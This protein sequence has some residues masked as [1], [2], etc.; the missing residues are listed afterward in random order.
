M[1]TKLFDFINSMD[2]YEEDQV[3]EYF[4]DTNLAKNLKVYKVQ[5]FDLLMKSLTSYHSKRNINSR[6]RIGLEEIEILI[7]KQLYNSALVRLK[8]IKELCLQ[9]EA[10]SKLFQILEF[11]NQFKVHY[12]INPLPPNDQLFAEL[13]DAVTRTETA[14]R[15]QKILIELNSRK[16]AKGHRLLDEQE[17]QQYQRQLQEL[18]DNYQLESMSLKEKSFWY[19]S[20]SCIYDLIDEE[21]QSYSY[22]LE[23]L[24]LFENEPLKIN[25]HSRLYFSALHNY[26]SCCNAMEKYPELTEGIQK[27]KALAKRFPY[28]HRNM[29]FIYY[30]ETRYYYRQ[31]KFRSLP[32]PL[33]NDILKHIKQYDLEGEHIS[34]SLFLHYTLIYLILGNAK[35]VQFYLRRLQNNTGKT[36]PVFSQTHGIIE[37]ISHYETGDYFII[38]NLLLSYK[39]K[40]KR[41]LEYTPFFRR[42]LEFFNQLGRVPKEE[43]AQLAQELLGELPEYSEDGVCRLLSGLHLENWLLAVNNNQGFTDWMADK[44]VE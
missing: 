44:C 21:E 11:E 36:P 24:S 42:A 41:E 18:Q 40:L 29:T 3:K 28:L 7:D 2:E 30:L 39:R 17:K 5:L 35:R 9:H 1:Q 38:N 15:L 13:E 19:Q 10:Y 8:K 23:A 12:S 26:L 32:G 16:N 31:S 27:I 4:S 25:S 43:H 37:L 6:I 33:E 22:K 14:Y 34:V 20:V